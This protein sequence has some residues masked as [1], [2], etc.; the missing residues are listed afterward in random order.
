MT[1]PNGQP[2]RVRIEQLQTG[3]T[4]LDEVLGGGLPEYSFNLIAGSPGSGKTTLTHQIM[5]ALATPERPALHFTVLG[6]PA[7]KMLRY[8]QQFSFFDLNAVGQSVRFVNLTDEVLQHDLAAVLDAIIRNVEEVNPAVVV[9]DSF[10]TIVRAVTA[11]S[12]NTSTLDVAEFLQRLALHLTTWQVT[13]FLVGEY[14]GQEVQDN[15]MFTIADGL[16]WLYQSLDRN[17]SVRKMHVVKMRGQAPMPGM[18]TM[19]ITSDGLQVFPRILRRPVEMKTPDGRRLS[20]GVPEL[21]EM[22]GGGI[23]SQNAAWSTPSLET[24]SL[25]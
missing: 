18:H 19:R 5:F 24:A 4:G 6:E 12:A 3:V 10:R 20:T 13:S 25:S 17:S 14:E 7:I 16:I 9:V 8:Q 15:P 21:D 1:D 23:S 22:M 11:P 2:K